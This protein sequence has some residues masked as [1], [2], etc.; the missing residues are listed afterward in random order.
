MP[1]ID[2]IMPCYNAERYILDTVRSIQNQS[3][4]NFKLICIDD[5]SKDDTYSILCKLSE[6][7]ER[8]TVLR[9]DHN[10][11]IAYTRNR[12]I[13]E[14]N[15]KYIAFIDDDD[16]VPRERLQI[17]KE[18]LDSNQN[19]G[20]VGGNYAIFDDTGRREVVQKNKFYS[21][22]EVRAVLPFVN[23]IPNGSTLV[24]RSIVCCHNISFH[25]ELGVEDYR[26]Y[27]E[28]SKIT[29]INLLPMVLLEHR[30][31]ATQYSSV[32]K[33]NIKMYEERQK[34]LD[35][36]HEMAISNIAGTLSKRDMENYFLCTRETIGNWNAHD[37]VSL[38]HTMKI[39]R[40]LVYSTGKADPDL[41]AKQTYTI[42]WRIFKSIFK[43]V[44]KIKG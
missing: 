11:G 21:A 23:I 40:R 44:L 38:L 2:I 22:E 29:D 7:D 42:Q 16:L 9:N 20:V 39:L 3:Y 10:C 1:E 17:C 24:R 27:T 25:E 4:G 33:L 6:K 30:V 37:I 34:F 18:Y 19:V 43:N 41:F 35:K 31:M 5:F 13:N 12:G 8:I 26:F 32:C 36:I 28:L 14:S 15:S